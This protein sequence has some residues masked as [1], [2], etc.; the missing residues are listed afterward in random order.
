MPSEVA[1]EAS[2]LEDLLENLG[3]DVIQVV[4]S[5][6]GLDVPVGDPVIYDSTERSALAPASVV[7]AVGVL[8][9]TPHCG[10]MLRA[11][12][13]AGAAAVVV[14]S[15][16]DMVDLARD[17]A[18]AGI[19]LLSVPE[20]MTWTQLHA[21]LLNAS[22]FSG[23]PR[24]G[25]GIAGVPLGDLFALANAVAGVVGG[26]VTI[27]DAG[28]RVLAYSTLDDQPIDAARR[29]SILGLQVPDSPA[30]RSLYRDVLSSPGVLT[31][32]G[33][34]LRRI[35]KSGP[36]EVHDLKGRSA[37]AIRAGSQSIGSIWV[38]HGDERLDEESERALA[39]AA[40]IAAPH[41]IQARAAR[42]LERRMRAEMLLAVLDGRE[43][44]EETAARLGF[45]PSTPLSVVAFELVGDQSAID[46]LQLERLV[47]LVVVHCG[48]WCRQTA[49]VALGQN[50]YALLQGEGELERPRLLRLA[51]RIQA[52]AEARL[53][54][55][56]L[57]ALGSTA[58]GV[59]DVSRARREAERVLTVLRVDPKERVVASVDDV[60]SEVVL[61]E[62]KELS[63]DHPNLVRGKLG[64]VVAYDV[65]HRS[66]YVPTL[67]AYL[68]AFGDIPAAAARISV[69]PN[70]FRYRMRR[71]VELFE[72][73]LANPDERLV[74]ELQLRLLAAD[75][76]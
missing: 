62:L 46:E 12:A 49:A 1:S 9:G 11:A 30:M 52:H 6:H 14:K 51:E 76:F 40:R 31:A 72:L 4:A 70:T 19:A 25:G 61:L 63:G 2:F 23:R 29:G 47:D 71:L 17:A 45:A 16:G 7:L 20:E 66:A 42:D 68:D 18:A 28:R 5:P 60:R 55:A 69:H 58:D 43:S 75:A 57:A 74:L 73:D 32:D 37:V 48:G 24:G 15:D 67:R 13:E 41:M 38:V 44:A 35:L 50:V 39:E 65:E 10:A 26:A 34:M 53:G 54:T 3:R 8:P 22:R 27:E 36:L 21:F 59:R 56:L 64:R 33:Q